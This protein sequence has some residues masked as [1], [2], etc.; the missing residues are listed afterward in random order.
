MTVFPIKINH[1]RQ[2]FSTIKT[3]QK[4]LTMRMV[5]NMQRMTILDIL[6]T[7]TSKYRIL[8][9][10]GNIYLGGV[11]SYFQGEKIQGISI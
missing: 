7:L 5:I 4:Q 11:S 10:M 1:L 2:S 6:I 3:A 8:I 9:Y